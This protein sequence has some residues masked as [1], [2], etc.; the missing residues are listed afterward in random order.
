M[1]VRNNRK[2][3]NLSLFA[4]EG[5]FPSVMSIFFFLNNPPTPETS[6]LPLPAPLPIFPP[7][8]DHKKA[9]PHPEKPPPKSTPRPRAVG[10]EVCG[11]GQTPEQ[12]PSKQPRARHDPAADENVI[13]R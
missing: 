3:Y 10:A 9:P 7:A 2:L 5:I 13:S 12:P 1:E 8:G 4:T 11:C 6:P